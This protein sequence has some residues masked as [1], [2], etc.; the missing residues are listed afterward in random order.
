MKVILPG[1]MGV[2]MSDQIGTFAVGSGCRGYLVSDRDR[3]LAGVAHVDSDPNIQDPIAVYELINTLLSMGATDLR[4]RA[5]RNADLDQV[6]S[7]LGGH[8]SDTVIYHIPNLFTT[9]EA[10]T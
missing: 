3:A 7:Q 1:E 10:V 9:L 4:I 6:L 8:G 5:T 2:V